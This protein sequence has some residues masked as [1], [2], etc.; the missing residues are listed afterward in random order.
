M[1]CDP[2]PLQVLT[3][4]LG[5][6]P[7]V[8]QG[9]VRMQTLVLAGGLGTRLAEETSK[10]PKPMVEIGGHPILWHIMNI[11]G[12][13]GFNDFVIAL[14]YKGEVIKD[15]FLNFNARNSDLTLNL[16]T[17]ERVNHGGRQP[18]W[19]VHLVDTGT[20]T[21]TGGRVRRAS[22]WLGDERTFPTTYGDGVA[23]VDLKA[24][25]AFHRSHGSW[26]P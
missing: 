24:L 19:T 2:I 17:G 10:V 8:S 1:A 23:D 12:C 25:V 21:Q 5:A 22:K 14:G 7:V 4:P 15:Y 18:P 16:A 20:A 11:Y 3:T 13:Q 9:E 26:P 6:N